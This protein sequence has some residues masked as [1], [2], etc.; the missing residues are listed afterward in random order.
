MNEIEPMFKYLT[1]R[2]GNNSFLTIANKIWIAND[3]QMLT[4]YKEKVYQTFLVTTQKESFFNDTEVARQKI[5]NWVANKTGEKIKGLI[6]SWIYNANDKTC[7][8]KCCN[9]LK[10][11]GIRRLISRT[12]HP[13]S[14]IWTIPKQFK[15]TT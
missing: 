3:F 11:N 15:L 10:V 4:S 7:F 5:N 9:I 13:E 2:K 14:F 8:S 12:L 6:S 1:E